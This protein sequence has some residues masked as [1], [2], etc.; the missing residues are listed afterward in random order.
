[1]EKRT[2]LT[3]TADFR[4]ATEEGG[5][6]YLSGYF[7][8]F[9]EETE[10]YR[11]QFETVA[12]E[13]IPDDI[14]DHDIRALFDHDTGKVLGRTSA[15]TMTLRKDDKG[16]FGTVEIN[17]DDPEALSIYAK[18]KRGDVSQASFGF[19]IKDQDIEKRDDGWHNTLT[20]VDLFEVSVVAFPAYETTEIGARSRDNQ[21]AEQE[22]FNERKIKLV[23]ELKDKWKIQSF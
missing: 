8:R 3:K 11:G 19:F 14:A 23:K 4:A 21:H 7:I 10:L 18:V 16:L 22:A 20:D 12:P 6:K 9:N 2:S 5:K 1:M 13:A 15:G 17:D